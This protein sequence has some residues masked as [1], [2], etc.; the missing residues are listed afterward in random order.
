MPTQILPKLPLGKLKTFSRQAGSIVI[1]HTWRIQWEQNSLSKDLVDL[2]VLDSGC[3]NGPYLTSF[4]QCKMNVGTRCPAVLHNEPSPFGCSREQMKLKP[5]CAI[6]PAH[7]VAALFSGAIHSV[8]SKYILKV[9]N[10]DTAPDA[11]L[12]SF[13]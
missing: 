11:L 6:L 2:P 8:V 7:T 12:N 5:L 4:M 13:G 3:V 1:N 10:L 9:S